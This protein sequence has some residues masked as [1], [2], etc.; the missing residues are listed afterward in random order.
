MTTDLATLDRFLEGDDLF[1]DEP[2]RLRLSGGQRL[3][4]NA[5][6]YAHL[7]AASSVVFGIDRSQ[8]YLRVRVATL[9]DYGAGDRFRPQRLQRDPTYGG[10]VVVVK[11]LL[12]LLRS[13]HGV[14][15]PPKGQSWEFVARR[16]QGPALVI[17][18]LPRFSGDGGFKLRTIEPN[19][20]VTD[21]GWVQA[22]WSE[23]SSPA[24]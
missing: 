6:A 14:L 13:R 3:Y 7:G 4:F 8:P 18:P 21:H 9:L 1:L 23:A 5:A 24:A 2:C 15:V 16:T 19:N 17:G 12:R 22:A 10:G 11:R 20:A